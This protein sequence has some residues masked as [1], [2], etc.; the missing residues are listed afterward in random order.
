[1]TNRIQKNPR[2]PAFF[3]NRA[4]TR[5]KLEK[6]EG[7]EQDA[8]TAVKLHTP[9]NPASLKSCYYLSQALLELGRPQEAYD[10]A[11]EA[12]RT[13]LASK[14][15]QTENLSRTVL[16]AKQQ[17]WAAKE[18]LRLRGMHDTLALVEQLIESDLEK[19]VRTLYL[20]LAKGE[21][22]QIG[23]VEDQ[24]AL[25]KEAERHIHNLREAFRIASKGEIQERVSI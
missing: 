21:I 24:K 23:C 4:V 8:R 3:T 7:V 20:K 13:S 10:T 19:D 12:Y 2:E 16:R 17:M 6:W 9:K 5:M 18:T 15:S 11:A 25:K 14:S 22:G 1:M